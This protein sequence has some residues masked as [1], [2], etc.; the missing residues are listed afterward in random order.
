[1]SA[2]SSF[3]LSRLLIG[4]VRRHG[5]RP[6][7]RQG[8]RTAT[9]Q[10]LDRQSDRLA[11]F[12]AAQGVTKGDHVA[13]HLRN[14]IEY[15]VAD[16]AILKLGAVKVPLNEYMAESELAYCLLHSS[17]RALISHKSLPCPARDQM[18]TLT[19]H[20]EV[21]DGLPP[22]H[23]R[24]VIPWSAAV[25]RDSVPIAVS[26]VSADAAL[27][28]YT[29]GTTGR[30][31]GVRHSQGGLAINI[32]AHVVCTDIRTDEVM[33]LLTPLPH[34]AGFF[35]Q[36]CLLQGGCAVLGPKFDVQVFLQL[37][38][39]VGATWTFAVPTMVYR[40]L[41]A[42][43]SGATL[44]GS[45][46]TLVYGAAPMDPLRLKQGLAIFGP[47]FIQIYGQT[48]CPN[49]IAT[50]TKS[51]HLEDALHASCGRPVPFLEV[52]LRNEDP[53]PTSCGAVGEVEVRSPYLLSEYHGDREATDAS[54]VDGWLRTGDLGYR[55]AGDYLFLVDRTKD[56]IIT[57]GL[58]VY[59]VEV[60]AA[61]RE[62]PAVREV[63]V[64]GV[65]DRDWGE[66][67]VAIVVQ[68]STI[69]V[70][71]LLRQARLR[72]SAYKV[73][74]R[75]VLFETLPLTRYGKPDKKIMRKMVMELSPDP[76]SAS[77]P[78]GC[79]PT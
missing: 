44:S 26:G 15:V 60:E 38:R 22:A 64:I 8:E 54:L 40:L 71:L 68:R 34:S 33:L 45:L 6:A 28:M 30:P 55:N 18:P 35:L 23:E 5:G 16:L 52:R 75:V 76:T 4:A 19:V 66:A 12:L 21:E 73:P 24:Q 56:M 3:T 41:D 53:S 51:D 11:A 37:A 2:N 39:A 1:M 72:L 47:I 14:C 36:A 42:C 62:D 43:S 78:N 20:V 29:G 46:R 59:S 10:E 74:K 49:L 32:L 17:T 25:E 61:L 57:G 77:G 63:A 9:Y 65:P 13:L 48:E 67:V 7:I 50:L 69:N 79:D 27:V 58:N 70:E 31:K